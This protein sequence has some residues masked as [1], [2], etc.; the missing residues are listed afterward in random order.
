MLFSAVVMIPG[1]HVH[2]DDGWAGRM[3]HPRGA[4]RLP[5]YQV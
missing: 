3:Q 5:H 4:A 1:L 2:G